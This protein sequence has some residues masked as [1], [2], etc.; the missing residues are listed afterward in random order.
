MFALYLKII[1]FGIAT[2][3][4]LSNPL[5]ATALMIDL[6]ARLS[7]KDRNRQAFM[8]AIYTFLIMAAAFYGGQW[9]MRTFGISI[10]GL[11]IAGGLVVTFIG[12]RML[13]PEDHS[14]KEEPEIKAEKRSSGTVT[15]IAFV[16]LAMPAV[17]GPGAIAMIISVAATL[18]SPDLIPSWITLTAP[19]FSF[20]FMA[21]LL[22]FSL[23]SAT[24]IIRA[25][26]ENGVNAISR[27]MGFLL[28]CMGVQFCIN[29]ILE[30]VNEY[31]AP[32]VDVMSAALSSPSFFL[33]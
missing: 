9:V 21:L 20:L 6:G 33:K 13:F 10:P 3:F 4:P 19:L 2:L 25:L 14:G 26:G 29:G 22:W 27:L 5:T 32:P 23:R 31:Q 1:F 11:R 12:F 28:I 16:P 30:I 24:Y 15:N 8:A 17:A 18:P 7:E